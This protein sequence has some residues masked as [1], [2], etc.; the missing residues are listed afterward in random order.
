MR[1][2]ATVLALALISGCGGGGGANSTPA[3]ITAP[4]ATPTTPPAP[5][6]TPAAAFD[7]AEYRR[8]DGPSFHNA[9]PAW[10]QGANGQGVTIAII[11][12]G[13][14]TA[15]PEF[16]GRISPYSAD[17]AGNRGIDP[18]DDHGTL[19]AQV[20]VAARDNTG[21]MGIAWQAS[22]MALRADT[23]GSCATAGSGSPDA[24]CSFSDSAIA[25]GI[26]R[27]VANGARVINLSMGGDGPGV[28]VRDAITRA[29]NAGLVVVV[30]AGNEGDLANPEPFA[31]G[32]RGAGNG[33]IIIAGS[34]NAAGEISS[35]SSR[36]GS[37]ASWYL[38]ALGEEI[39]CVYENGAI[40]VTTA[41]GQQF[42]T[43]VS[44]TSFSAPQIAGAAALLRQAFP[45]LTAVQVVDLLLRTARDAGDP[46]TDAIYGHGILDIAN[47]FA[48]QGAT[49]LAGGSGTLLA[50]ADASGVTSPAMGDAAQAA[51]AGAV[52][53][54]SYQRAYQ[55]D[56]GR[57]L[58][59]AWLRPRLT[60]ALIS[61]MRQL[62]GGK[63]N[64][65]LAFSVDASGRAAALP[66]SGQL[67]LGPQETRGAQVLAARAAARLSPR[68]SVAIAYAQG[69][70][71]LAA[72]VRGSGEPAFLVAGSPLDDTGFARAGQLAFALRRQF[73]GW[74]LTLSAEAGKAL[75][76]APAGLANP[77]ATRQM[78]DGVTR[79]GLVLD[80]DWGGLV[81]TLGAA[82]L[83]EDRT[84]LGARLHD[85]F[86]VA[87]ADSLFL[88]AS[89]AW[90][91][92]PGWRIGAAWRQGFTYARAAGLVAQGSRL[93]SNGWSFD[94]SRTALFAHDDSL[95][96]RVSQPLRVQSGGIGLNLPVEWS[97]ETLSAGHAVRKLSLSPHGREL[98]TEL[99][100][101]GPLWNGA[102]SVSLFYRKDPG[103]YARLPDDK[104]VAV[105]W[106]AGF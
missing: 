63:G 51:S 65:A 57:M 37:E 84:M 35:F 40:K 69:V 85:A 1:I 88:D 33:N 10:Q 100:W 101:R 7:T 91:P 32:L 75:P 97:Y 105:N 90:R 38:S 29:A 98:A 86:G 104:G 96:L 77:P 11:D 70:D 54:D 8:S 22:V 48:P 62:S 58:R 31:S 26:D 102:A 44:G 73:G 49:G 87:G 55:I 46:G 13:I 34:V 21:I 9:V 95:A 14:D 72:Q 24:G 19:V 5:T 39:C 43:V 64:L 16:A 99:A 79:F 68:T 4:P 92:A 42:V 82:W 80:R 67:R 74:G 20:A 52:I 47:A 45:N 17:V 93:V 15:N 30:S 18:E 76:G 106:S 71:G 6:P 53:L 2:G 25:A 83:A 50:L 60:P 94:I 78:H 3:P 27:A 23:P 28:R 56:V 103:H 66:W 89:A 41:N 81:T 59:S 61:P 12:T 36:A